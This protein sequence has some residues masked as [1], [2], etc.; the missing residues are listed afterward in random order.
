MLRGLFLHIQCS[1][2]LLNDVIGCLKRGEEGRHDGCLAFAH[3]VIFTKLTEAG[4]SWLLIAYQYK[5]LLYNPNILSFVY[6]FV[7]ILSKIQLV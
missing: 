4:L 3:D 5:K 1:K 2:G 6:I 7:C